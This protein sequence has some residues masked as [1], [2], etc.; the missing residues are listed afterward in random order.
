VSR[1]RLP[2]V[3]IA[4]VVALLTAAA[5]LGGDDEGTAFP[6]ATLPGSEGTATATSNAATPEATA[7][8]AGPTVEPAETATGTGTPTSIPTPT[9]TPTATPE[10]TV[11]TPVVPQP[12][13]TTA[14]F[15]GRIFERPVELGVYPG[16]RFFVADQAGI[17]YLINEAGTNESVLLDIR[18]QVL[19]GGNEEGLLSVALDP[20]FATNGHLWVYYSRANPRRSV[21][22]RF[23]VSGDVAGGE[24]V[25][26]EVEQPFQN[27]NGG[28]IRFGPDGMLYLGFGDGGSGGDPLGSGQ[29][30]STLLGSIIRIDVRGAS[31]G[32]PYVVPGD[33]PFVGDGASAPEVWA[34]GLRNPWRMNWDGGTLWVGDVGQNA[35]EEI[36]IARAGANLG[37]NR[38]EGNQCYQSGCSGEGTTFPVAV[39]PHSGGRCSVTGGVVYRG[40]EVPEVA[41]SYLYGD[42]CSGE[43]WALPVDGSSE[44]VLVGSGLGNISSFG[45]DAAGEVYVLR[46]GDSIVRIVSP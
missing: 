45:V 18:G 43:L 42:F 7:T 26:L 15:G 46:F 19:R 34:Y 36:S 33:N 28:A 23:T 1:E 12:I 3:L 10:P 27:H 9:P 21:L 14:A 31:A 44:P 11:A 41:G 5:C 2:F 13:G 29:D 20:A 35:I 4:S 32:S 39:Y 25:V 6:T 22:S 17:V 37:W 8:E 24:L 38:L 40:S 30:R 16:Q